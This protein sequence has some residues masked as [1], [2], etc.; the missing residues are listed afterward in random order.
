MFPS[1]ERTHTSL[2][3]FVHEGSGL[4]QKYSVEWQEGQLRLLEVPQLL[5]AL[6]T[7]MN[8]EKT[9]VPGLH[10]AAFDLSASPDQ[11]IFV[12][13][14]IKFRPDIVSYDIRTRTGEDR[15]LGD[16]TSINY[17]GAILTT[18][19]ALPEVMFSS[20]VPMTNGI[21]LVLARPSYRRAGIVNVCISNTRALQEEGSLKSII[22]GFLLT[23][24]ESRMNYTPVWARKQGVLTGR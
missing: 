14:Q 17:G 2:I 23:K 21:P 22:V 20:D 10:Q 8:Y 4:V 3:P 9:S 16:Y 19:L 24:D 6:A 13:K 15:M 11:T 18:T 5:E 12:E 1:R 7:Q